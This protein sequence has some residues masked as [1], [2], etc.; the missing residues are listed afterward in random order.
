ML[1]SVATLKQG[2]Y[3][4][5]KKGLYQVVGEDSHVWF[6][7]DCSYSTDVIAPQVR[8]SK[9]GWSTQKLWQH[10]SAVA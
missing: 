5:D 1:V 7:E 10:V 2:D 9:A 3:L 4:T 6:V 8:I